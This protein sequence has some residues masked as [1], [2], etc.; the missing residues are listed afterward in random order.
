MG[1]KNIKISIITPWGV[2]LFENELKNWDDV[3]VNGFMELHYLTVTTS[4]DNYKEKFRFKITPYSK[5]VEK[6]DS[7]TN[8]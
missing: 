3:D 5:T 2:S 1:K 7:E 6:T 4:K 8:K